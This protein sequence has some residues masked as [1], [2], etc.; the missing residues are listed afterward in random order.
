VTQH[1]TLPDSSVGKTARQSPLSI[2]NLSMRQT[3]QA[4]VPSRDRERLATYGLGL[5]IKFEGR[6]GVLGW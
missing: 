2:F 1:C 5:H 3:P 4:G 6:P